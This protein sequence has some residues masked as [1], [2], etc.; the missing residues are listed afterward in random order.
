[1]S[2]AQW[3]VEVQQEEWLYEIE[4]RRI[5]DANE[6]LHEMAAVRDEEFRAEIEAKYPILKGWK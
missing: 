1:M 2:Q 3:I 6:V 5:E 4:A